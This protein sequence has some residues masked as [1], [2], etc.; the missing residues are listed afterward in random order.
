MSENYNWTE[1]NQKM[2]HNI[3]QPPQIDFYP[4]PEDGIYVKFDDINVPI[5]ERK[6][7]IKIWKDAIDVVELHDELL[8][9]YIS[10]IYPDIMQPPA[11]PAAMTA[12]M[13]DSLMPPI[14]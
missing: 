4:K 12:S 7:E 1:N 2:S 5:E 3:L 14:A 13:L 11:A 8:F 10:R 9:L 6:G